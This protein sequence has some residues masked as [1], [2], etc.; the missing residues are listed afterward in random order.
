MKITPQCRYYKHSSSESYLSDRTLGAMLKRLTIVL[1]CLFTVLPSR[2]QIHFPTDFGNAGTTSSVAQEFDKLVA[3][4]SDDVLRDLIC[5]VAYGRYSPHVLGSA[6]NVPRVEV[7]RRLD[8]LRGWGLARLVPGVSGRMVVEPAPGRGEQTLHRWAERYCPLGNACRRPE[9]E[10]QKL[11]VDSG[12]QSQKGVVV[13]TLGGQAQDASQSQR[14]SRDFGHDEEASTRNDTIGGEA[15]SL[16]KRLFIAISLPD[17]IREQLAEL[18]VGVP[19][20]RWVPAEQLHITLRFIG[21][22]DEKMFNEIVRALKS[23]SYTSFP[24]QLRGVGYFGRARA[25]RVLWVGMDDG[26]ELERLQG[27]VEAILGKVGLPSDNRKYNPHVALAR[28]RSVP[29]KEVTDYLSTHARFQTQRF[30]VDGFSLY[31]SQL[32]RSG[33]VHVVEAVFALDDTRK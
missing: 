26:S 14:R 8:T 3:M 1:V 4:L 11:G 13:G 30:N 12:R 6:L 18:F 28:L 17:N 7:H 32:R 29:T 23:I 31:S 22:V 10:L 27:K 24:L 20:A 5:R 25:P 15:R 9:P 2:A 19:G 33:A 21:E 16:K